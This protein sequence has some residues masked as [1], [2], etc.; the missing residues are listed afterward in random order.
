MASS[1]SAPKTPL[2]PDETLLTPLLANRGSTYLTKHTLVAKIIT[3]IRNRN[4]VKE[5]LYKAWQAYEGLLISD[6][7]P[8]MFFLTFTDVIH[9]KD[10][11]K[12]SPWCNHLVSLQYEIPKAAIA[13]LDFPH[14]P[15][16]I[17]IQNLPLEN[18]NT[19]SAMTQL[20]KVGN[21]MEIEDPLVN[22]TLVRDFIRG[23][24]LV[25]V[26]KPLPTGCWVPRVGLPRL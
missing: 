8:N 1:S 15:F 10:V 18:L 4:A 14:N 2:T 22:G 21:I 23:R 11:M 7:G 16:R 5:I 26:S 24:V 12:K 13:E 3:K 17:Q 6:R 9:A 25:D 20:Q 19:Q